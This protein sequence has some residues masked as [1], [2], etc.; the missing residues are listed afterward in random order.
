MYS[1]CDSHVHVGQ[2]YETYT[3]P[4]QLI[5]LLK[6]LN[7][8][9]YA[10]S[11]TSICHED[12]SKVLKEFEYL[13]TYDSER[14]DPVLWL[15]PSLI[16]DEK[17][18]NLFLKSGVP[19]R[20][21]K[22]H[23]YFHP[24]VWIN[25]SEIFQD[26]V[27]LAK[28]FGLPLLIH[29]GGYPNSDIG[30]WENLLPLYPDQL[31]IFAHC[32]PFDQAVK[33]LRKYPNVYGDLAFVDENDFKRLISENIWEK[34]LWGSDVPIN[35]YFL[36]DIPTEMYYNYRLQI[37]HEVCTQEQYSTIVFKNYHK[38]IKRI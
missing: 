2:F 20:C 17:N 25:N 22:I 3:A 36:K 18:L 28:E 26:A 37:L 11:S 31:F 30:I 29:T 19:W 12:Y 1:I 35:E 13:L 23:P 32:R 15:T 27:S 34:I 24:E 10:V 14:V 38:L 9:Y 33:I 16:Q 7:L 8:D 5:E 21:I 6:P 4:V